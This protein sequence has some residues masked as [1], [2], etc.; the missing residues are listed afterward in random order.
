MCSVSAVEGVSAPCPAVQGGRG[1]TFPEREPGL[2][3]APGAHVTPPPTPHFS[4]ELPKP[5][6]AQ[7][8]IMCTGQTCGGR[9]QDTGPG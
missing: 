2:A 8:G 3:P 6:P 7:D 5:N 1:G 4:R 9:Q